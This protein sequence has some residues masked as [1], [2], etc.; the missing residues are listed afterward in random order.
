[1]L[2]RIAVTCLA[3]GAVGFLAGCS[4][5]GTQ[6]AAQQSGLGD[7]QQVG[8]F[9]GAGLI[10][11]RPRPQFT[12]TDQNGTAFDFGAQ[13]KGKPT[14]LFYGY[15]HCPDE[16]PATMADV[17]L[18]LSKLPA[19]LQHDTDVVFVTTDPTH[20]SPAR[21]KQWLST[22]ARGTQARWIGLTGS[23]AQ[24]DSAQAAAHIQLA[25]DNGETHSTQLLLFGPDD[26][27]R[28]SF[29]RTDSEADQIQH[30]LPLVAQSAS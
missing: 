6:P 26:Y 18:A 16:C 30:D 25:E 1:M 23:Q 22:F 9:Q 14:L 3:L 7:Q 13:T 24:I 27:A 15:T 2:K 29:L 21:M 12:L 8:R 17:A 5:A 28:V 19:S 4:S 20:D 10:P 11:A